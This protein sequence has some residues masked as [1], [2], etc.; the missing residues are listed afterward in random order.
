[1]RN[2][3]KFLGLL[4]A[5]L[6]IC[7]PA[8]AGFALRK[9]T[10]GSG[11]TR[12]Q[13][14]APT[15]VGQVRQAGGTARNDGN[16]SSPAAANDASF[17]LSGVAADTI[18]NVAGAAVSF[19]V[20]GGWLVKG[21]AAIIASG[22]VSK[23]VDDWLNKSMAKDGWG[24]NS[25]TQKYSKKG[26]FFYIGYYGNPVFQDATSAASAHFAANY[27]SNANVENRGNARL[28][29]GEY[30]QYDIYWKTTGYVQTVQG[31]T[32]RS[33][34][35][36]TPTQSDYEK[37]LEDSR[38][39][40]GIEP[41]KM[42]DLL[43]DSQALP[44]P[45]SASISPQIGLWPDGYQVSQTDIPGD[46]ITVPNPNTNTQTQGGTTTTA[47]DKSTTTNP[48]GTTSETEQE[49]TFT[50]GPFDDIPKLWERKYPDGI[51]GV[52]AEHAQSGGPLTSLL[53][54][55][56]SGAPTAGTCPNWQV[57]F[58]LGRM[59]NYGSGNLA[60][61]CSIW[62]IL[63]ACIFITALFLARRLIFGG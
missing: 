25:S 56:T 37:A 10:T 45:N 4:I 47:K 55:L 14:P 39:Q 42:L 46:T 51:V 24:Y 3:T 61:D 43:P 13:V 53:T 9:T 26:S 8:H 6:L 28:Q 22:V 30:W 41:Q 57:S 40:Q 49:V 11:A 54:T 32:Y 21:A 36:L 17:G 59:G 52:M 31:G 12:V 15:T 20:P 16:W 2:V 44:T 63:R 5:A 19:L 7:G 48:D 23:A 29:N 62:P 35:D 34:Q 58:N 27:G 50:D 38:T 60:P 18:G 33:G 1:M